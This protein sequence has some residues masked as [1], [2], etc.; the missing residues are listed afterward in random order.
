MPCLDAHREEGLPCVGRDLQRIRVVSLQTQIE[1]TAIA[2]IKRALDSRTSVSGQQLD[3]GPGELV[4]HYT[5]PSQKDISGWRGP[6][7]VI[8]NIPET[9]NVQ[10]EWMSTTIPG[11]TKTFGGSWISQHLHSPEHLAVATPP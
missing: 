8:Q 6:A 4:D 11:N 2:K 9:G 5:E 3:Y 7:T 1:A 10:L